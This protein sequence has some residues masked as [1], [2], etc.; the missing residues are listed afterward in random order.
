MASMR[1]LIYVKLNERNFTIKLP[2]SVPSNVAES[3]SPSL[4]AMRDD[5][6]Q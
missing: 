2:D 6:D 1:G 3:L 5:L 4:I